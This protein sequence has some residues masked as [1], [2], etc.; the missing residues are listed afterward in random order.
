MTILH[1]ERQ[2]MSKSKPFHSL[3]VVLLVLCLCS[4]AV[5]AMAQSQ[6]S[7]GQITGIVVDNQGAAI[8]GA[9]ISA[10]NLETGLQRKATSNEEGL[11]SIV[12][13]PPGNYDV[14]AEASGF[15]SAKVRNVEVTV[16][17]TVDVKIA[18]G[19]S[20]V[21][22]VVEVTGGAI[23]IQTTRSE[24]DTVLNEKAIENLPINGRRFQD[25]VTLTPTAQVDPS[26]GQISIAGQR[27]INANVSVD[28]VD[29]NQ[30]FFGGIRG[31]ERSNT[32]F[33]IPQEAIKEFQV[34]PAGYSAEFGRS[35][36]GL[37]NAVTKSGTNAMHGSGF[38]LYRPKQL[39]AKNDFLS[40]V[41]KNLNDTRAAKGLS[42]LDFTPAPNREMW[43]GSF[44]GPI[45]KD[46]FFYFGS[47]EGQRIRLD[48][49][50]FFDNLAGLTPAA[51][52]VEAF[53]FYQG[54][55]DPY[56]Q[57]NDANAFLVRG[58]YEV[59]QNHR[60]NVRFSWNKTTEDN[61]V[62]VGNALQPTIN[63]SLS[64]NGTE[65]DKLYTITGQLSSIFSS[66]LVNELRTQ[67]AREERPRPANS[68]EPLVTNAIGNV[69]TVSFLGEN[70]EFDRRFQIA[71]SMTW[72]KSNHTFKVGGEYNHTFV[73]QLFGFNQF[74]TYNISGTN[75][76][77]ILDILSLTPSIS[78][79]VQNR[80]DC[81]NDNTAFPQCAG[82][83][84]SYQK[85][86]GNL[87]A[88]YDG[89]EL[90]FFAQD[91]WRLRPNFTLN[92]GLRWEEQYN[93]NPQADNQSAVNRIKGFRFPSGISYDPTKIPDSGNQW[94]PRIGFAW[95]PFSDGKTVIRGYGGIYYAR[96][97]QILLA[98]PVNNF[99]ATPGDVSISLPFNTASL[100]ASNPLKSCRTIFCQFNLVG[101]NLN[102]FSLDK[103][104]ILSTDQIS[105]IAQRLG[106]S[107]DP[108]AGAQLIS[109]APD[110]KNPKSYQMGIGIEREV[111]AGLT[112]GADFIYVKA[113]HL[114][115]NRE[116]NIPLPTV[117]AANN[118]RPVYGVSNGAVAR[119]LTG[120]TGSLQLRESSAKSLY[121]AVNFN[122]KLQR[123]WGQINAF[124]TYSRLL[125]DDDNERSAGGVAYQDSYDFSSEYAL[126]DL[127]R[128]HQFVAG[129]LFFLPHGFDFSSGIRL[130][131]GRP[132]DARVGNDLNQ[133]TVNN[134]RPYRATGLTFERNAFRNLAQY[135][136]DMRLQKRF[137]LKESMRLVVSMEM[138][139]IFNLSNIQLGGAA[140]ANYC[141]PNPTAATST[142]G[143]STPTNPNFLQKFD[144]NVASSRLGNLLLTNTAGDGFQ[145]QLAARFQF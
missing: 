122:M 21:T 78:T 48:R 2:E 90:A 12:L 83:N 101:V 104:P 116:V 117:T 44:G 137:Q 7:S 77:V 141:S 68:K 119:P 36:G 88:S 61:A 87:Q 71:D 128:A 73:S 54:L 144:Q 27:G 6:A 56:K 127:D 136:V 39:S 60:F 64:N 97:P 47:Y 82:T 103:L 142:C 112:L 26:R 123:K 67:F 37:V 111:K 80:F 43:G 45:K 124:Y 72:T 23:K 24:S 74:G 63:S 84:V 95:D 81:I 94:G 138:F 120:Q 41:E 86:I 79:G 76:P 42:P 130:R 17:R 11:Y 140:V 18:M 15:A 89:D 33:T 93:P 46:K 29:Y 62:S 59:N 131:S 132:I 98:A 50:V 8:V 121:R 51:N 10:T 31:G 5:P 125:S 107:P 19:V 126:S 22:E 49:Q 115:R 100:P 145:M 118:G 53:N 139:N 110:F 75:F 57:T 35:T 133:D 135:N 113:V 92:Y 134:D 16:G 32:A 96:T 4:A 28:G 25:F 91:S 102:N 30:P 109:V 20:G 1:E 108:I 85:Q 70:I 3:C 69:G 106:L 40:A 13:L 34:V 114:E 105:Q 14:S 99:R 143:F 38:F 65:I 9:T 66:T 58:D 52:G 55:Q 129:P